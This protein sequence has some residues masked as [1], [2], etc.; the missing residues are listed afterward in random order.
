MFTASYSFYA[1]IG[2]MGLTYT[3]A[4][5]TCTSRTTYKPLCY[6]KHF[7]F[8]IKYKAYTFTENALFSSMATGTRGIKWLLLILLCTH[9][10]SPTSTP[11]NFDTTTSNSSSSSS[12]TLT[13]TTSSFTTTTHPT[14]SSTQSSSTP[15]SPSTSLPQSTSTSTTSIPPSS[16]TSTQ[17]TSTWRPSTS[18]IPTVEQTIST[19]SSSS[20]TSHYTDTIPPTET[21]VYTTITREYLNTT[22]DYTSQVTTSIPVTS[23][24][25]EGSAWP[26]KR[27]AVVEGDLVLGGLMMVHERQDSVTCGPIMPQGGI[28]ALEAM[29][30][31]VDR[32]NSKPFFP[33]FTLGAYVLDDCDKDTYGLEM[34]VD[35]IKGYVHFMKLAN[36]SELSI[37]EAWV[38]DPMSGVS[39][40]YPGCGYAWVWHPPRQAHEFQ[41]LGFRIRIAIYVAPIFIV[42]VNEVR[43]KAFGAPVQEG[44]MPRLV[45]LLTLESRSVAVFDGLALLPACSSQLVQ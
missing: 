23:P 29:L 11:A 25:E 24:P 28:Q 30:F 26:V 34:A 9:L 2:P 32:I 7:F 20:S 21:V 45:L 12:T 3:E 41:Y 40:G 19:S 17:N 16:S 38:C 31:T 14:S 5:T 6:I 4:N 27:E 18:T 39:G 10:S 35:F 37:S 36:Y 44:R 42:D 1:Y 43:H 22:L 33:G 13:S 8:C 15:T